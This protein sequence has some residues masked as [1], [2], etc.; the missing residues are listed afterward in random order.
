MPVTVSISTVFQIGVDNALITVPQNYTVPANPPSMPNP[1]T[2]PLTPS[3]INPTTTNDSV[4]IYL[5]AIKGFQNP[6]TIS[7]LIQPITLALAESLG[8]PLSN[9]DSTTAPW[10]GLIG[11]TTSDWITGVYDAPHN[12]WKGAFAFQLT[13]NNGNALNTYA[14]T[15]F[16][17]LWINPQITGGAINPSHP[18]SYLVSIF[19]YDPITTTYASCNFTL[20]VVP[21][22]ATY[23]LGVYTKAKVFSQIGSPAVPT[24]SRYDYINSVTLQKDGFAT[25]HSYAVID[26][27]F[28]PLEPASTSSHN[29]DIAVNIFNSQIIDKDNSTV[30]NPT[31]R[32][33]PTP[34]LLGTP[35]TLGTYGF[36][37][38]VSSYGVNAITGPVTRDTPTPV[39]VANSSATSSTA[40]VLTDS[41]LSL[42]PNSLVG[43]LLTYV[44]GPAAG[45]YLMV[46][47]NTP[48]TVTTGAFSPAPDASGDDYVLY[49]SV[50]YGSPYLEIV[51]YLN[52]I[53]DLTIPTNQHAL[54][55]VTATDS[56]GVS[57]SAY[58]AI[59][60]AG[61]T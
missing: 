36:T 16:K 1:P 3:N 56:L 30:T 41:T 28:Y 53:S 23:G 10:Q 60:V 19:A 4:T 27:F 46:L 26:Y 54:L 61:V 49:S 21:S 7:F 45:Q 15:N 42:V 44:T 2:T 32:S 37:G 47:S 39:V 24:V 51:L 11:S 22:M 55:E 35:V 33:L 38:S 52:P 5:S 34:G 50:Q 13:S 58:T 40:T 43:G 59:Y 48:T 18:P 8:L 9:L 17:T 14:A 29:I 6:L 31:T 20:V 25:T 57:V 12:G